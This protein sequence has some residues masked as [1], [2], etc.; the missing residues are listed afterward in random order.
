MLPVSPKKIPKRPWKIVSGNTEDRAYL[1]L[2]MLRAPRRGR[3]STRRRPGVTLENFAA[4]AAALNASIAEIT[5]GPPN[6][7]GDGRAKLQRGKPEASSSR[8]PPSSQVSAEL[9]LLAT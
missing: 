2:A 3:V 6:D 5:F 4:L 8:K 1:Y 9:P 7:R